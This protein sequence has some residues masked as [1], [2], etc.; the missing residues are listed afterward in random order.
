MAILPYIVNRL[1]NK[2]IKMPS[3][4]NLLN[5]RTRDNGQVASFTSQETNSARKITLR[6]TTATQTT[7]NGEIAEARRWSQIWPRLWFPRPSGAAV[8]TAVVLLFAVVEATKQCANYAVQGWAEFKSEQYANQYLNHRNKYPVPQTMFVAMIEM[9][10]VAFTVVARS[11]P[12]FSRDNLR[13][14]LPYIVPSLIYALQGG[15]SIE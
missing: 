9:C 11:R 4:K 14:S 5:K 8:A 1:S 7:Q 13:A 15:N 12:A 10:K 2:G 3:K 6:P